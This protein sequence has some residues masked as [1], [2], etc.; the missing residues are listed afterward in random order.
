M[1][2]Q[3][4]WVPESQLR[5]WCL[6]HVLVGVETLPQLDCQMFRRLFDATT[7]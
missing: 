5:D 2:P 3:V 6:T 7:A 1:L 4:E